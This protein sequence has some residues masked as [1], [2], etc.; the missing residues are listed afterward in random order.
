MTM[1]GGGGFDPGLSSKIDQMLAGKPSAKQRVEEFLV[2][3]L[4]VDPSKIP[5]SFKD[6]RVL[7]N[8]KMGERDAGSARLQGNSM[9]LVY[10]EF[11]KQDQDEPDSCPNCS[12]TRMG[13]AYFYRSGKDWMC[14]DCEQSFTW[15]PTKAGGEK[16][17][18]RTHASLW[19]DLL[20]V[21]TSFLKH[22]EPEAVGDAPDCEGC[23]ASNAG[24]RRAPHLCDTCE[25]RLQGGKPI[26]RPP[27]FTKFMVTHSWAEADVTG[28]PDKKPKW[29][30]ADKYP[31]GAQLRITDGTELIYVRIGG[32]FSDT[33][34]VNLA[35]MKPIQK[36]SAWTVVEVLDDEATG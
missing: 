26:V 21:Y 3:E 22:V 12:A 1:W 30:R 35:T 23:G 34:V 9:G 36:V 25:K 29:K 10:V 18:E 7:I 5:L 2:D 6:A 17:T 20:R 8:Q 4:H 13:G 32:L 24:S 19:P 16:V 27:A 31:T 15:T 33:D 11:F 14:D 28:V